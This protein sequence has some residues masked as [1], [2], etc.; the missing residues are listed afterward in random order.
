MA[1]ARAL[2]G[3]LWIIFPASRI[4]VRE[5]CKGFELRSLGWPGLH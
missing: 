5:G 1:Y 2:F 4:L 3:R